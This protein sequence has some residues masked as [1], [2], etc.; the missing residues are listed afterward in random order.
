MAFVGVPPGSFLMGAGKYDRDFYAHEKPQHR[1]TIGKGFQVGAHEVTQA[2]WE[3]LM[4]SNPSRFQDP[5]NPVERVSYYDVLSF[6]AKLNARE[7]TQAYRLPTEA[8]WEYFARA[9]TVSPYFFGVGDDPLPKYAWYRENSK[10]S[11]HPVGGLAPNPWGLYDVYGNV[12]EM[13]SDWFGLDYYSE[14]PERD[15]PGPLSGTGRALRGGSWDNTSFG[16]RSPYRD[17]FD[18]SVKESV[19]GFRLVRDAQKG[20]AQVEPPPVF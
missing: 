20:D 18:P 15:P 2:A 1:V 6:I 10:R 5:A 14:S 12:A 17:R 7:G 16:L 11:T 3:E 13:A 8:E 4:G 9:G 19:I